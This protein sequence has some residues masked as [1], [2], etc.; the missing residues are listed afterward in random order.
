MGKVFWKEGK[1]WFPVIVDSLSELKRDIDLKSVKIPKCSR[2][3]F[4]SL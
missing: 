1:G 2:F 4:A 3:T